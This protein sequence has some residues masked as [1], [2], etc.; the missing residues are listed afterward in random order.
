[1]CVCVR[2]RAP[3]TCAIGDIWD[4]EGKTDRLRRVKKEDIL[5]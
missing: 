4:A 5:G 3:G 2:A 1:M